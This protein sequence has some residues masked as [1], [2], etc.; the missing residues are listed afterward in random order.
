MSAVT[1]LTIG[2]E[3]R[4]LDQFISLLRQNNITRLID[5]RE[6]PISRKK[7][8][9][10][11]ALKERLQDENIEYIHIKALGSPSVIRN[12]LK[13]DWDYHYFFKAYSDYLSSNMEAVEEVYEYISDGI[14][15]I[16]CFEQSYMKCHRLAVANKIKEYDGNGLKIKHI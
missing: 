12:K 8:F 14:N 1:L 16:M 10:K 5:I 9:S 4:E 6:I 11:S 15:C 2:Y 7:G 3:G 13:S